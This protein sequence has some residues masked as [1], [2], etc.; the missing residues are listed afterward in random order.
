MRLIIGGAHQGKTAFVKKTMGLMPQSC[1]QTSALTAP[2]VNGFHQLVRDILA[3]GGDPQFFTRMLIRENPDVVILC[4]EVGLG[5]VP[6]DA[7]QR[8]WREEVGR[9]LC[10]LAA[11]ADSVSRIVAGLEQKI[12]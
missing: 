2:A 6:L 4:D 11:E 5:I 1:D 8:R 3:A 12:K 9:C 7:A 10:L